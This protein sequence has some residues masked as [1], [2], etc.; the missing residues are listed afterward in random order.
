[1]QVGVVVGVLAVLG[2]VVAIVVVAGLVF[3]VR[4]ALER[5]RKS[6]S[7]MWSQVGVVLRRRYGIVPGLVRAVDG[8]DE[9]RT[10]LLDVVE[11]AR[12]S[13]DAPSEPG[14]QAEIE[15][16]LTLALRHVMA[17]A[18]GSPQSRSNRRL[19]ELQTELIATENRI[20]YSRQ[21]FNSAAQAYNRSIASAP[22]NLL[23]HAFGFT[24]VELFEVPDRA[25]PGAGQP[26][27]LH[28]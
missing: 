9:D 3:A 23:A 2:P 6:V 16:Q 28:S 19:A 11:A 12:A 24:R 22:R 21:T 5:Q 10:R 26:E 7:D 18:E 13:A 27:P 25:R 20:A 1:M 17:S 15:E 4:N 8:L 14:V